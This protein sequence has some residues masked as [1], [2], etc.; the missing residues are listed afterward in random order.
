MHVLEEVCY[1]CKMRETR[2]ADR[3]R[4]LLTRE[5]PL[6]G[7]QDGKPYE[8]QLWSGATSSKMMKSRLLQI[9]ID[10]T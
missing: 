4:V 3:V 2:T 7:A 8:R 1:T 5:A 10:L 6:W 9:V